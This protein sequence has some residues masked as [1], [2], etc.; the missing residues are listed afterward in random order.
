MKTALHTKEVLEG[1]SDVLLASKQCYKVYKLTLETTLISEAI[2][3]PL[4]V[5][6]IS[7]EPILAGTQTLLWW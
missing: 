4:M 7:F 2:N 6:L 3:T 1:M 5:K